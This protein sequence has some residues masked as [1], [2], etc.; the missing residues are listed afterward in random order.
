MNK[1]KKK[2]AISIILY[3]LLAFTILQPLYPALY[4]TIMGLFFLSVSA[5]TIVK[6]MIT[7]FRYLRRNHYS[8]YPGQVIDFY[9]E[10][11]FSQ[12]S[13]HHYYPILQYD[14]DGKKCKYTSSERGAVKRLYDKR[15]I[16][17]TP[18]GY[19]F[20]VED[21][22]SSLV[23]SLMIFV[24]SSFLGVQLLNKLITAS[25]GIN[26]SASITAAFVK[27]V[28]VVWTQITNLVSTYIYPVQELDII[29]MTSF[30]WVI[31]L[32]MLATGLYNLNQVYQLHR[33]KNNGKKIKAKLLIHKYYPGNELIS[34]YQYVYKNQTKTYKSKENSNT[35]TLWYNPQSDRAYHETDV[36]LS[37]LYAILCL[38]GFVMCVILYTPIHRMLL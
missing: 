23:F 12:K 32:A 17:E 4:I 9:V 10:I 33:A 31:I 2:L 18:K 35:I 34:V 24:C 3:T 7:G 25:T 21:L 8:Q 30:I 20:S 11:P 28:A 15:T 1:D 16:Y 38:I 19:L 26:D 5:N 13:F 37:L 29:I 36:N 14:K 22:Y 27:T 6:I